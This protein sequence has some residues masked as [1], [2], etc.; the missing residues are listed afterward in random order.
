MDQFFVNSDFKAGKFL[1]AEVTIRKINFADPTD[2]A[3]VMRK[4]WFGT[5][6]PLETLTA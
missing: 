1:H 4:G 3:L 5:T 6:P 2:G